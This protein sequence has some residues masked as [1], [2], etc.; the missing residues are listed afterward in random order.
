[1]NTSL[2]CIQSLKRTVNHTLW[3][4]SYQPNASSVILM[5]VLDWCQKT[6]Y[7]SELIFACP[8][9]PS[10]YLSGFLMWIFLHFHQSWVVF[11]LFFFFLSGL[12]AVWVEYDW[13]RVKC[14]QR[15]CHFKRNVFR[16][17]SGVEIWE[18][19]A[20]SG[21]CYIKPDFHRTGEL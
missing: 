8:S 2:H 14:E 20:F 16:S 1:M 17:A 11:I 21:Y 18:T 5:K 13:W 10:L 12:R 9:L 7:V 3:Q 15:F 6:S 19:R 4:F